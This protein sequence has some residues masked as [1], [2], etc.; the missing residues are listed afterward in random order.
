M[1]PLPLKPDVQA[2]ALTEAA[3]AAATHDVLI[4]LY[5]GQASALDQQ[6]HVAMAGDL[7]QNCDRSEA[8]RSWCGPVLRNVVYTPLSAVG[9]R[10]IRTDSGGP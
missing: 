2:P 3:A 4:A 5:P 6:Y 9:I 10:N 8:F 7:V 1:R